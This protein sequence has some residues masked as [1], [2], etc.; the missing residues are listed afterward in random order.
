VP[1]LVALALGGPPFVD[2]LR[3]VWDAGDAVLP[4]DPG[5]P[6]AHTERLLAALAP[7]AIV[8]SDGERRSLPGGVP[9]RDGDA[10]VV[11]SSGTTGVPKGAVHTHEGVAAAARITAAGC[12]R[13]LAAI[14]T[15]PVERVRWLACLPLAHVGGLSVVTRALLGGAELE[16]HERPDA[17]RIDDAARR[18]ATHV[19]LVPTL[20][21]RVDEDLWR[22]VLLGGS[23]IPP[24]RPRHSIATYGM[25]ETFGG[26]V[27]DGLALD[28]VELRIAHADGGPGDPGDDAGPIELR[29]PTLLRAYRHGP[30]GAPDPDGT[31][32][33]TGDG[34][35]RTGDLGALDAAGRLIVRGRA[36]DLIITGGT[37]VWPGPVED[38]L[39]TDPAVADVA[40]VGRPD[41]E[42]GQRV[43]AVVV[44]ADPAEPPTLDR[45]RDLVR[46]QLP[47]AAAPKELELVDVLPRTS[48]GKIARHRLADPP[49]AGDRAAGDHPTDQ[50]TGEAGA[51]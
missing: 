27:Y 18:G 51:S 34:W 29:S 10:V 17:D 22:V 9:V 50:G 36:D 32:P 47:V 14:G 16:V 39:R 48:L 2:A 31:D 43:V 40:V 7:G 28:D 35:Y 30:D 45:L 44:P 41:D 20:L 24:A 42:W 11:A 3:R 5:A 26:V 4:L 38:L 8:E 23:A 46:R 12:E 25:T 6:R 49:S 19:S 37:N 33:R 21:R 13:H 1:E 15:D